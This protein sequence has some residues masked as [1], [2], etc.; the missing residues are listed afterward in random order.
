[1]ARGKYQ[2]GA[3]ITKID[4]SLVGKEV[5]FFDP[6]RGVTSIIVTSIYRTIGHRNRERFGL[7]YDLT[8]TKSG[9]VVS[10]CLWVKD[11]HLF[12]SRLNCEQWV[13]A[14]L[15]KSLADRYVNQALG[16]E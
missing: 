15:K 9:H 6:R 3:P 16:E 2:R 13:R 5:W 8:N 4:D 1:M 7:F 10:R 12:T 11:Y 14:A